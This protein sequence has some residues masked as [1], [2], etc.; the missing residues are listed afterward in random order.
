MSFHVVVNLQHQSVQAYTCN[1]DSIGQVAQ[2][3]S[4]LHDISLQWVAGVVELLATGIR[5][6]ARV[7]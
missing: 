1:S 3:N 5:G 4:C 6:G 7:L 2:P